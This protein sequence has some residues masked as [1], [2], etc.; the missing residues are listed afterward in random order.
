MHAG[1]QA[2]GYLTYCAAASNL[3]QFYLQMTRT[4]QTQL[5]RCRSPP[6]CLLCAISMP[7]PSQTLLL[8]ASCAKLPA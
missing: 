7:S 8:P 1:V 5:Y 4:F 3:S 2:T 6:C